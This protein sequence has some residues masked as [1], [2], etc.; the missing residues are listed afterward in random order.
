MILATCCNSLISRLIFYRKLE[1]YSQAGPVTPTTVP[2]PRFF[3]WQFEGCTNC[4]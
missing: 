2:I 1:R 3:F 4:I